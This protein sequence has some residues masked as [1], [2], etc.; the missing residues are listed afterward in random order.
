M[1]KIKI[2]DELLAA[3]TEGNVSAE[4]AV[5][6][7]R[8]ARKDPSIMSIL[9]LSGKIDEKINP[10]FTEREKAKVIP[11]SQVRQLPMASLAATTANNDCVLACEKFVLKQRNHNV[12]DYN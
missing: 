3:Y 11:M 7:I 9:Q 4:E 8:A 5:A 2:T 12:S 1:K 10:D 6:V